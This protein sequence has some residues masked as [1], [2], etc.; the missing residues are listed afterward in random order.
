MLGTV[1]R[2]SAEAHLCYGLGDAVSVHFS[3]DRL[4]RDVLLDL[5]FNH[6]DFPSFSV[7]AASEYGVRVEGVG[8]DAAPGP[9]ASDNHIIVLSHLASLIIPLISSASD[10]RSKLRRSC[11]FDMIVPGDC[12]TRS[13]GTT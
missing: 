5:R 11:A 4:M 8:I 12:L 3:A 6:L 13:T 7:V 2:A 9:N 1:L 10:F